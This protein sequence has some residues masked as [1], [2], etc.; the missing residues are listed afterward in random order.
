MKSQSIIRLGLI[1]GKSAGSQKSARQS[2]DNDSEFLRK[3]NFKNK[4]PNFILFKK[5]KEER[6]GNNACKCLKPKKNLYT[7]KENDLMCDI[8]RGYFS[9]A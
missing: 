6:K 4:F 1:T 3:E 7:V 9:G 2:F 8:R 5:K